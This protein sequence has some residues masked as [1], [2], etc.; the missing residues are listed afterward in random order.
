LA[1]SGPDSI[2]GDYNSDNKVDAADYVVW[3]KNGLN[4]VAFDEWRAHFGETGSTNASE[5]GFSQFGVPE[6]SA[7]SLAVIVI[8]AI[9][10][11]YRS[12]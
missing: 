4:A 10:L 2:P 8:A 6:P 12:M 7:S 9:C 1:I 11:P 5:Q 3:R